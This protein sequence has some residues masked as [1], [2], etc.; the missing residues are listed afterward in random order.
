MPHLKIFTTLALLIACSLPSWADAELVCDTN[1]DSFVDISDIRTIVLNRNQPATGPDD[2][3]DFDQ[4]GVINILDARGCVATCTLPRCAEIPITSAN[5]T[6][7][8]DIKTFRFTWTDV[9]NATHYRLL[10]NPDGIS[11]FSQVGSDIPPAVG[12]FDH[13]V[14]LHKRINAQYIFQTCF[15][16][17]CAD[18]DTFY[19]VSKLVSAIGYFKASNTDRIDWFGVSI[20]SSDN[21][22]TLA[23]GAWGEDSGATGIDGDQSDNSTL[24]SGAVYVFTRDGSAWSQ[25]AYIKAS[26]AELFDY[27][28]YSVSLSG[29]G[30]TL[31]VGAFQEDSN[32]SGIN[33]NQADN[34]AEDAGAVYV[35]TRDGATW[36]QQAYIKASNTDGAGA[37][38]FDLGDQ[39]GVVVS[40]S[41]D[42]NTLAVGASEED[43]ISTGING[44]QTDNTAKGSG[45]VYVFQRGGGKWT[46]QAYIKASNTDAEDN[47]GSAVNFSDDG[48]TLAVAASGER[49]NSTGING[50]QSSNSN[51]RAGAVYIFKRDGGAWGQQAYIKASNTDTGDIFGTDI[52]LSDDG[53]TLAVGARFED[54][55]ATGINGDQSDESAPAAGAAY[56][57]TRNG[58]A[59]AQQAYVKASNT[60]RDDWFGSS[61]SLSGDGNTLAVGA[62]REDSSAA[63]I[64]D[65][66]LD[67]SRLNAG[68]VY[69]FARNGTTWIQQAYVKASNTGNDDRFGDPVN[70]SDDGN[71]LAVGARNED[72]NARGVNGNQADNLAPTSGAV[73]LY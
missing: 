10:E 61:V 69:V 36:S 72:S 40:L 38:G 64:N 31:A 15:G 65:D 58:G 30:N 6:A 33:G 23:V 4:N 46:Q 32:A 37:A 48:N 18:S 28:G 44:N 59:W 54:S 12:I 42:G 17:V 27:F 53:N 14:P 26:K 20:S 50:N 22:D 67:D 19:V 70:L 62:S 24:G 49:S 66:Q 21:G 57:F 25:Q 47:F 29:D 55:N 51:P 60:T 9:P 35:F 39:F 41:R 8:L 1:D 2:P 3:M 13:Y 7:T 63:G 52:S 68:A 5:P 56:I 43:S 71:T 34:S 73:Y 11:G 45:A 16:S